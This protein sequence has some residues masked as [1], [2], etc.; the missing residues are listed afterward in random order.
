MYMNTKRKLTFRSLVNKSL[1]MDCNTGQLHSDISVAESGNTDLKTLKNAGS[2]SDMKNRGLKHGATFLTSSN[3]SATSLWVTLKETSQI[4]HLEL[5]HSPASGIDSTDRNDEEAAS[6]VEVLGSHAMECTFRLE[7]F[8]L[9]SSSATTPRRMANGDTDTHNFL[10]I[11]V[12]R[13]APLT[14][15]VNVLYLEHRIEIHR[16][17]QRD[18]FELEQIDL[19]A[20]ESEI[21]AIKCHPHTVTPNLVHALFSNFFLL[22]ASLSSRQN[23]IFRGSPTMGFFW[24]FSRF[25]VKTALVA[26]A[27]KLSIDNDIWSLNTTNGAD[28][29]EKL[30]KYIVPGTIVYPEQL[31]SVEEVTTDIER[32]WN[33]GVD[34]AC[35]CFRQETLTTS[36]A[37]VFIFVLKRGHELTSVATSIFVFFLSNSNSSF[38]IC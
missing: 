6:D 26:G 33:K 2:L 16:G 9:K 4:S 29:Y 36:S 35:F 1:F 28:L 17:V 14:I 37:I 11:S 22:L 32:V 31:P 12:D 10:F 3:N 27:I 21:G 23:P 13:S 30:R 15:L 8:L 25:A 38:S 18:P 7:N 24:S 19:K 34:K 20:L 5:P